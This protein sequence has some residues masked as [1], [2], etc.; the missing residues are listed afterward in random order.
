LNPL[1]PALDVRLDP[2]RSTDANRHI[3]ARLV[4]GEDRVGDILSVKRLRAL[5]V[6][7]MDVKRSSACRGNALRVQGQ[8]VRCEWERWMFAGSPAPIE[9]GLYRHVEASP[10]GRLIESRV[11]HE[12]RATAI[13]GVRPGS[14]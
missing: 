4:N 3:G 1:E 10:L 13:I 9:T 2:E 5:P 8:V 6:P 7:W 14:R 12:M 11:Y